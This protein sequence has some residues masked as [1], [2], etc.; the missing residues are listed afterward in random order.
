MSDGRQV[1]NWKDAGGTTGGAGTFLVGFAM[2]VAGGWLVTN[3]VTVV[4][5]FWTL[6]GTN[7][8]GLSL[9][10][11][12]IGISWLFFN[13]R[14]PWGWLLTLGGV[15]IIIVG[16]LVNLQIFFRPA[17]LFNT[18]LMFGLLFGGLGLLARALRPQRRAGE[19]ERE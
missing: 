1:R 7:T 3:Q 2:T 11:V 4:S 16:V 9:L 17:S 15:A 6:F 14:S 12:L 19:D 8:F 5:S 10:P 13:G 18:L